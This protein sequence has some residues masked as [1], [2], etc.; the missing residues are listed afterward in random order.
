MER[1]RVTSLS[2][3]DELR[4]AELRLADELEEEAYR[5]PPPRPSNEVAKQ[6]PPPRR[7]PL[8]HAGGTS[9]LPVEYHLPDEPRRRPEE[10]WRARAACRGVGPAIFYPERGDMASFDA[11][12]G[13]CASCPVTEECW[14]ASLAQDPRWGVWGGLSVEERK[15]R[16]AQEGRGKRAPV[17]ADSAGAAVSRDVGSTERQRQYRLRRKAAG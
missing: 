11:A 7:R 5:A 8:A 6:E 12:K 10:A 1:G 14:E 15:V 4:A 13:F 9:Y 3:L 2:M 16:R 17:Y